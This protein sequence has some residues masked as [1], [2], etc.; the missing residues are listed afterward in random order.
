MF[1]TF[2]VNTN[3]FPF[4]QLLK[5]HP[6]C[7]TAER[8]TFRASECCKSSL[9]PLCVFGSPFKTCFV[10]VNIKTSKTIKNIR[11]GRFPWHPFG[12]MM[13]QETF[14]W[15]STGGPTWAQWRNQ[16]YYFFRMVCKP[17]VFGVPLVI[18]FVFLWGPTCGCSRCALLDEKVENAL[19]L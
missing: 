17:F 6:W 10:N 9:C 16:K 1:R 8:C 11:F 18:R 19:V 2:F 4:S 5:R 12:A 7:T 15:P 3:D 14:L 13:G